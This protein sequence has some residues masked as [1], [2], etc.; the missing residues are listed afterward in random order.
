MPA[1]KRTKI[2]LR[3]LYEAHVQFHSNL[4]MP[5]T[6]NANEIKKYEHIMKLPSEQDRNTGL[7]KHKIWA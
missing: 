7:I 6:M 1:A 5:A 3:W 2:F 4:V